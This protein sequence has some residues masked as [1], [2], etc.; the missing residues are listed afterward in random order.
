MNSYHN[1]A[2]KHFFHVDE[3]Y[4]VFVSDLHPLL[5]EK[6]DYD[7]T[8]EFDIGPVVRLDSPNEELKRV[9]ILFLMF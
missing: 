1:A 4:L 6:P 3:I 2:Q 8:R 9:H 7:L 5:T